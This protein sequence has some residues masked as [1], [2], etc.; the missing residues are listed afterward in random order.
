MSSSD[1]EWGKPKIKKKK[2]AFRAPRGRRGFGRTPFSYQ[3][4]SPYSQ[5]G[6]PSAYPHQQQAAYY[7]YGAPGMPMGLSP[8]AGVYPGSLQAASPYSQMGPSRGRFPGRPPAFGAFAYDY[9]KPAA[10]YQTPSAVY[11]QQAPAFAYQQQMAYDPSMGVPFAAAS[12]PEFNT[13]GTGEPLQSPYGDAIWDTML[14]QTSPGTQVMILCIGGTLLCVFLNHCF[15]MY[16][17]FNT[18]FKLYNVL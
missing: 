13:M 15:S 3:P 8:Q 12:P 9:N 18:V 6:H 11:Q 16:S 10:T 5:F 4:V 7:A 2:M 17:I 14:Q 1:E